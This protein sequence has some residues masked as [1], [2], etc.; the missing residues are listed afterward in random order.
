MIIGISMGQDFLSDY[1]TG[2]TRFI[3]LEEKPPDGY[4]WSGER[5]IRKQLTSRPDH[6]WP[7]LWTKLGRN[8]QQKERQ[9]WSN[10][11]PQLDN[12]RR[13]RGIYFIVPEDKE[14]KETIKNAR[15]KLETP[16]APALPCKTSKN[17]QHV[18]T[19]GKSNKIISKLAC[20][21]GSQ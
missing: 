8:A 1:W 15:K 21:F 10:E 11:Q 5:L 19:C 20:F 4:M 16:V 12:V 3:L 18:V 17:S 2:F 7:E 14:F 6:L 13:L 9:K